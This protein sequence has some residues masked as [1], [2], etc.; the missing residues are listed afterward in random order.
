M[1]GTACMATMLLV[2]IENGYIAVGG[3]LEEVREVP[4]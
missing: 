4:L 1:T 3:E 2:T